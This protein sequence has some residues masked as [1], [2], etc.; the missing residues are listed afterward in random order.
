MLEL[1]TY[2]DTCIDVISKKFKEN[3]KVRC[4]NCVKPGHLKMDYRRGVPRNNFFFLER[5]QTEYPTLLENKGL[6]WTNEF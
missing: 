1:Y 3:Q 6:S 2:D 5:I 4:F